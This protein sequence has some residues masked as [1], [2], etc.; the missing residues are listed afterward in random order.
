MAFR[1]DGSSHADGVR[2]EKKNIKLMQL[3]A[4][5]A[6]AMCGV[7]LTEGAYTVEQRGGT[8]YTEDIAVQH[9]GGETTLSHKRKKKLG[10]GSFDWLNSTKRVPCA[11]TL[12]RV[13]R[14]LRNSDYSV[15]EART[16]FKGACHDALE[17]MTSDDLIQIIKEGIVAKYAGIDR[18]TVEAED[19]KIIYS[20]EPSAIPFFKAVSLPGTRAE[21]TGAGTTSRSLRFVD[22]GGTP[23]PDF[24][25]RIRVTSNNGITAM[26]GKNT[27]GNKTSSPVIKLQQ[28]KVHQMIDSIAAADITKTR[29]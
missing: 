2:A 7:P 11:A 26:L 15:E 28:D 29:I 17:T 1:T 5:K 13:T 6:S 27:K 22:E 4:K 3:D 25:L 23:F 19:E 21:M 8:Q 18:I 20:F 9:D 12:K 24:G 10:T 16:I 14:Q